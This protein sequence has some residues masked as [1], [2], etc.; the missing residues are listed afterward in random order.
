MNLANELLFR[1]IFTALWLI[2]IAN[3]AH[4]RYATR[5]PADKL[6]DHKGR[7]DRRTHIVVM[8]FLASFL[9]GGI[10]LYAI[11]PSWIAFLS[12]PLPAWFRF[13]MGCVAALTIPFTLW[14]YWTLGKNWVHALEPSKFIERKEENLVTGGPY[15]YVR[16]PIYLGDFTFGIAAA[17]L[18][19]NWLILL[20]EAFIVI[21]VYGQ[22][23]GEER[24]L[25]ERF[26][27]EYREYVKRTPRFIPKFKR[28]NPT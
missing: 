17:L 4:V 28:E 19:S 12:I 8:A 6:I 20:P 26:G 9:F 21:L 27:D 16:N 15:R 2:V 3:L 22:I 24:M 10:I 13:I 18:A 5:E 25:M 1:A 7:H 11:L 23:D 14:G